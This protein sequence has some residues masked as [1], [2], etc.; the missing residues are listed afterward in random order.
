[1][2]QLVPA[3]PKAQV[4]APAALT[5]PWP[6]QSTA[7][8]NSQAG[9]AKPDPQDSQWVPAYPVPQTQLPSACARP[10]PKQV[11][12]LPY[13]Q[14]APTNPAWHWHWPLFEQVPR[15]L[16]VVDALQKVHVG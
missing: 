13:S 6:L 2:A 8:L 12:L 1:V 10:C 7:S 5:V 11:V 14:W 4:H 3:K 15:L 9:P 16:Q